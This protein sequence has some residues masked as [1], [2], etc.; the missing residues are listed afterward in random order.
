M[1]KKESNN[2]WQQDKWVIHW[3][4]KLGEGSRKGYRKDFKKWLNF[5][6]LTPTEQIEKRFKDTQIQATTPEQLKARRYFESKLIELTKILEKEYRESSVRGIQ[7]TVQSFFKH[8]GSPLVFEA[9]ELEIHA[10]K[11]AL[12]KVIPTS[13][14]FR[15]IYRNAG[16]RLKIAILLSGQSGF[17]GNDIC[18][19]RIE[20]LPQLS[21][22]DHTD[23]NRKRKK[24]NQPQMT[25]LSYEL[26]QDIMTY[27]DR[28]DRTEGFLLLAQKGEPLTTE[29]LGVQFKRVCQKAIKKSY[30]FKC[31]RKFF[32]R[33]MNSVDPAIDQEIKWLFI[34]HSIG[35]ESKYDDWKD[36]VTPRLR[37]YK[38]MFNL[39]SINGARTIRPKLEQIETELADQKKLLRLMVQIYGQEILKKAK[40]ELK[41]VS[42]FPF[43]GVSKDEIERLL[44][45]YGESEA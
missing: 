44:K 28:E 4:S 32:K 26:Q 25:F 41:K 13:E 15:Q 10:T 34:G 43:K 23:F 33:T 42:A 5:I 21:E 27:L 1:G 35:V 11:Q 37:E 9:S 3:M 39:F 14:E 7:R 40:E 31:L 30:P 18:D 38:K 8:S 6:G 29:A 16:L 24:S 17:D 12:P 22:T 36:N 45:K 2:A 19:I 20:E